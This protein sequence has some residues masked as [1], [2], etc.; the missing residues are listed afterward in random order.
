LGHERWGPGNTPVIS[1]T[2]RGRG[3]P[4]SRSIHACG[5]DSASGRDTSEE[6]WKTLM[7]VRVRVSKEAACLACEYLGHPQNRWPQRFGARVG[8]QVAIL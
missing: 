8:T 5:V 3:R 2:P 6:S 1:K 7:P 4:K